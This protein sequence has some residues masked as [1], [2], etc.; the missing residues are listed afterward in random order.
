MGQEGSTGLQRASAA[1]HMDQ[2]EAGAEPPVLS[3]RSKRRKATKDWKDAF[4][5]RDPVGYRA[6]RAEQER[7][8]L[9]KKNEREAAKAAFEAENYVASRPMP[10][11]IAAATTT[12]PLST[13]VCSGNAAVE[14]TSPVPLPLGGA[15]MHYALPYGL[16]PP[17]PS[18]ILPPLVPPSIQ[19]FTPFEPPT[20]AP[21]ARP[22]APP[23]GDARTFEQKKIKALEGKI[24][25]LEAAV[26]TRDNELDGFVESLHAAVQATMKVRDTPR[27]ARSNYDHSI[28]FC[29]NMIA[30]KL[31]DS[32]CLCPCCF[33]LSSF[34]LPLAQRAAYLKR[35]RA[36][37][38]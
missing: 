13:I 4:K 25:E 7:N 27:T 32:K 37:D 22:P 35:K 33:A 5:E 3:P 18:P 29:V 14:L 21:P 20:L 31:D 12:T 24:K 2:E 11:P 6:K 16:T 38:V 15:A 28:P 23:V 1:E 34:A 9:Q 19:P 36:E 10:P 26:Q 8:R 30:H 17:P